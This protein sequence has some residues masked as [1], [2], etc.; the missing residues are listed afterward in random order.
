MK[1]QIKKFDSSHDSTSTHIKTHP[2]RIN[3][4]GHIH[5]V[6]TSCYR[7]KPFFS[8]QWTRQIVIDAINHKG[9]KTKFLLMSYV[10]MPEHVHFLIVPK[11]SETIS[12]TVRAVKW[13][14]SI[15]LLSALRKRGMV[16]K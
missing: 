2:I 14:S 12:N 16:E 10:I 5:F 4:Q 6:T 8:K 7:R 11:K 3:Q 13:Y 9:E 15:Q 1:I